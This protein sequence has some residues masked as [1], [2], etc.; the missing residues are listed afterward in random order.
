MEGDQSLVIHSAVHLSMLYELSYLAWF[1]SA[2]NICCN[3]RKWWQWLVLKQDGYV[4]FEMATASWGTLPFLH[5]SQCI[6]ISNTSFQPFHMRIYFQRKTT[7][8][9]IEFTVKN[10]YALLWG[11]L[12]PAAQF[13]CP[14]LQR[15]GNIYVKLIHPYL[16]SQLAVFTIQ[17][18]NVSVSPEQSNPPGF[19]RLKP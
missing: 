13:L 3:A 18:V 1:F 14:D 16:D 12:R 19:P 11:G 9:H 8:A 6:R 2:V 17:A 4:S 7:Q 15:K 5:P 10:R